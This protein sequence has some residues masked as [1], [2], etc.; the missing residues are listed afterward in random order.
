MME[1]VSKFRIS[2]KNCIV[3]LRFSPQTMPL[4]FR[5]LLNIMQSLSIFLVLNCFPRSSVRSS[6]HLQASARRELEYLQ[7]LVTRARSSA[8]LTVQSHVVGGARES[9][10][11]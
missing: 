2:A 9:L 6:G 11:V 10:T 8:R 7:V 1:N 3:P 4:L 5:N